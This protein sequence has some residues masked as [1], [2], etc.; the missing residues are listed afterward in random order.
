MIT[1]HDQY[2]LQSL[3]TL[4]VKAVAKHYLT[5]DN[6][7]DDLP[8][9]FSEGCFADRFLILG[10]GANVLFTSD[11][12]GAVVHPANC[13]IAISET[14]A[15]GYALVTVGAAMLWDDVVQH[16]IDAG[17]TGC[18][19][20]SG[21]PADA[22]GAVVQ[23]IGAYGAEI[24][25]LVTEVTAFDTQSGKFVTIPASDCRFAYRS[26]AFKH[27]D[28]TLLI[29]DITL[30]LK[31]YTE[32]WQPNLSY[33]GLRSYCETN[34]QA[35]SSPMAL[36]QAV[37]AIRNSKL[38][39]PDVTPNAGSFF[40]NP[41]V[42]QAVADRIIA[43]YPNMPYWH[44]DE[45]GKVKLSGGWLIEK[46]GWKGRSLGPCAI[47]ARSALV[48]TNPGGGTGHDVLRLVAAVTAAVSQQ[49]GVTLEPEV[50][51]VGS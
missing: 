6:P 7:S 44:V 22:G 10:H 28:N 20:L 48:L 27:I 25:P 39:D 32:D 50:M 14:D 21:I 3:N 5:F 26:S 46:A 31:A 42:P 29:T 45:P 30:R 37:L 4:N 49:F 34:P 16:T 47:D 1:R 35:A 11:F 17:L 9:L 2:Q 19:N 18:E 33:Q 13:C 40:K 24:G 12:D 15:D 51:F 23:N 38:P 36:R 8:A 41:I 43:D